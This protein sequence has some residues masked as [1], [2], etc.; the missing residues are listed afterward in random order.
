LPV[1][2]VIIDKEACCLNLQPWFAEAEAPEIEK[3]EEAF[4]SRTWIN[5]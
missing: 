1:E 5:L 2:K 4:I 3:I